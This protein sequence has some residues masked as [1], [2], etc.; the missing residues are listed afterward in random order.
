MAKDNDKAYRSIVQKEMKKR[1]DY[2]TSPDGYN[3]VF[4]EQKRRGIFKMNKF[5]K[6][7]QSQYLNDTEELPKSSLEMAIVFNDIKLPKRATAKSAGYDFYAPIE[8]S[9]QPI[10]TG[11]QIGRAHV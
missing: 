3:L 4:K 1:L 8:F 9:L 11:K 10:V 5:H 6:V 7:T 2:A